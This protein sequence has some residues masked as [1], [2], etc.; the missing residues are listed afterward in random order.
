MKHGSRERCG[1]VNWEVRASPRSVLAVLDF[2]VIGAF[3]RPRPHAWCTRPMSSASITSTPATTTAPTMPSRRLGRA[4][5]DL[6][7]S[8]GRSN[9]FIST[10][11]STVRGGLFDRRGTDFS[12]DY[13]EAACAKAL[14]N[15]GLD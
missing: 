6:L 14:S 2:G 15:L 1:I 3:R 7:A 8:Y 5:T 11:A 4:L 13:L 12:A 9:L 10:K